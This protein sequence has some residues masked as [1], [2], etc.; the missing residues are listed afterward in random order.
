LFITTIES[1]FTRFKSLYLLLVSGGVSQTGSTYVLGILIVIHPQKLALLRSS[2]DPTLA[3]CLRGEQAASA[4]CRHINNASA[5]IRR[6]GCRVIQI[7][8]LS[9]SYCYLFLLLLLLLFTA[10]VTQEC[11][12]FN[13]RSHPS[14][15]SLT[16]NQ[17]D[18]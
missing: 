4:Y 13:R 10:S 8:Y 17:I 2:C 11:Y 12:S 14:L 15:L 18:W 6:A 9:V 7:S 1:L 3:W 16:F 5:C